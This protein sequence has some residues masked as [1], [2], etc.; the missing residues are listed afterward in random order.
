MGLAISRIKLIATAIVVLCFQTLSLAQLGPS[1][2]QR[3]A[4][5]PSEILQTARRHLQKG[6]ECLAAGETECARR[7]F[8]AAI[9]SILESGIDLRASEPLL[10]GWRELIERINAN[11]KAPLVASGKQFWKDQEFVGLPEKEAATENASDV[12]IAGTFQER[13]TELRK[14]FREI[15]D[16]DIT[17]TGADHPEHMRLYGK[18]S[19]YDIRVR[20]LTREQVRF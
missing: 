1:S 9:E 18:G 4:Q 10:A 3:N 17:L 11:E 16:R 12:I 5:G 19:A 2:T 15:Y 7:E 6:E 8:D 13:F 14:R 20:D